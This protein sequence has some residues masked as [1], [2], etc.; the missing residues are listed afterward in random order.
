MR[1][2]K[3]IDIE[4]E[5]IKRFYSDRSKKYSVNNPYGT[6]LFQDNHPELVELRNASEI[7]KIIPLLNLTEESKILDVGCG[8]GRYADA[9]RDSGVRISDYCGLDFSEELIDIAKERHSNNSY[10]FLVGGVTDISELLNDKYNRVIMMG[11]AI[12]LNEHVLFE[13][14]KQIAGVCAEKAIVV[15]REAIGL[16][17]RLTLKDFYSDELQTEYNAIYRTEN[18]LMCIYEQTLVKE[19]FKLFESG[20]LFEDKLNNRNETRQWYYVFRR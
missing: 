20:P 3:P 1:T 12:Y 10:N 7:T 15:F 18:E 16:N 5:K 6:T 11:V 19:G 2:N 8:M 14:I 13:G 17:E 4:E 9:I